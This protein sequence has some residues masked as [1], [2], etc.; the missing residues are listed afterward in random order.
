MLIMKFQ[1]LSY[2]LIV[3]LV[4]LATLLCHIQYHHDGWKRAPDLLSP[5]MLSG[6]FIQLLGVLAFAVYLAL[7]INQHQKLTPYGPQGYY[8]A[9]IWC[10]MTWKW[11]FALFY[12]TRQYRNLYREATGLSSDQGYERLP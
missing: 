10:L 5:L 6:C 3:R 8:L 4:A 7:A 12:F 9:C 1:R 2:C 11:G